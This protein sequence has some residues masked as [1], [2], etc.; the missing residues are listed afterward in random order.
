MRQI[1]NSVLRLSILACLTIA[2]LAVN[3]AVS[4]ACTDPN[5]CYG[6]GALQS[7]TTGFDNTAFGYNA[8]SSNTVGFQNTAFGK[9]ALSSNIQGF[10]NTAVGVNALANSLS[11]HSTAVGARALANTVNS[12]NTAIGVSALFH[13]TDGSGNTAIGEDALYWNDTGG[14]NTADGAGALYHNTT[15]GANTAAGSSALSENTTG[16]DN[17]ASGRLSLANNTTGD[18]NTASGSYALYGN[19]TGINNTAHGFGAL[20]YSTTGYRNIAL[21]W[22]AGIGVTTGSDNIIIGGGNEGTATDTG[23]IR[24]GTKAYQKKTFIAGIR[25]VQTGLSTAKTVFIDA[26]GQLGTIKSSREFKENIQ[27]MGSASERLLSLRPVTFQYKQADEDGSKPLQFG[28]I[29]EE[30]A[31]SFPELAIYDEQGQPESVSY[32]LLATLLLNEFQ[33][34]RSVTLA[35]ANRIAALEQ[36]SEEL[37]QLK[38]EI[39]RMAETIDRLDHAQMVADAR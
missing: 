28:L 11:G 20:R 16:A 36:Q 29:A 25:N 19:T 10:W 14:G 2:G 17:T 4:A 26:N 5:T 33:K 38:Q 6:T 37:A 32:H 8:L 9:S 24:I 31:E 12:N 22:Q 34:E 39:A 3:S 21:G 7:N 13:N 1:Q 30:V 35:Q 27:P 23:V 15:G 18:S